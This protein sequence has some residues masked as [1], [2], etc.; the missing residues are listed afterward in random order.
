MSTD[1]SEK[2]LESLIVRH[3]TGTDGLAVAPDAVGEPP[4]PY[5]GSGYFAGSP[6]DYDRAHALDV[7]QLFAFLRATQPEAFKKLGI[8]DDLDAKDINLW[9]LYDAI[10]CPT[11]VLRGAQSDVLAHETALEMSGRGPK[12]KLVEVPAVGHAPMLLEE[13][14]VRIVQDFLLAG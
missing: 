10:R 12:A 8:A 6:K 9:P 1:I 11:M 4:A 5:G 7:P 13:S 3:M 14:Q 2:G